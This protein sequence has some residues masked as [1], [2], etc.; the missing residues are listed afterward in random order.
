VARRPLVIVAVAAA[1]GLG[2][3]SA[4]PASWQREFKDAGGYWCLASAY[5]S[6]EATLSCTAPLRGQVDYAC[7]LHRPPDL[8]DVIE[9]TC[10]YG[11]DR[12]RAYT[13][14]TDW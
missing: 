3:A 8:M 1:F 14:P 7:R 13:I 12:P 2:N 6:T 4:Q 10:Q 5:G 11:E 9:A